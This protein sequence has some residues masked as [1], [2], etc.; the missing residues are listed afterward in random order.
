MYVYTC[1]YTYIHIHVYTHRDTRQ[2]T[3][4][5][6]KIEKSHSPPLQAKDSGRLVV[7]LEGQR[8]WC[9]FQCEPESLRTR[10]SHRRRSV[11][12]ALRERES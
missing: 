12:P 3:H 1:I 10:R 2:L 4:V 7:K 8:D 11:S 5:I 9:K 6:K